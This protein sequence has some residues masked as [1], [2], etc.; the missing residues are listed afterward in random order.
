MIGRARSL[1]RGLRRARV[2]RA[3]VADARSYFRD[4][5]ARPELSADELGQIKELWGGLGWHGRGEWHAWYKHVS[6][7]FDSRYLPSELYATYILPRLN[8]AAVSA[9]WVD[10]SFFDWNFPD[11]PFAHS[12][13]RCVDGNWVAEDFSP[14]NVASVAAAV[15]ECGSVL[16]K[17]SMG[18]NQ[19]KGV[20]VWDTTS[21]DKDELRARLES[22]GHN[23]VVQEL[24]R[25]HPL[26]AKLNESSVNIVRINTLRFRGGV[27]PLNAIVRFG[28]PGSKTDITRV[29]GV[30]TVNIVAVSPDGRLADAVYDAQGRCVPVGKYG[31]DAGSC[32]PGFTEAVDVVLAVHERLWHFDIVGFDVAINENGHPIIIEYNTNF[33]GITFPQYACGPF[34]GDLTENV[35]A[36]LACRLPKGAER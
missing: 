29:D 3:Q 22:Y 21:L 28:V 23:F 5:G 11:A 16:L 32:V 15:H 17:P 26:M 33:P 24:I 9:A 14:A 12:V 31:L 2:W 4:A 20:E 27:V 19:G 18:S 35:I 34:F 13:A 10:K 25:Q 8:N 1:L 36:D 7:A 30:E 6:G